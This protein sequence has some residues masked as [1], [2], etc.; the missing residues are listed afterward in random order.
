MTLAV[1]GTVEPKKQVPEFQQ[2]TQN[3]DV[4]MIS[5]AW[6]D[7]AESVNGTRTKGQQR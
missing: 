4:T 7:E 1:C 6:L 5:E 3:I 2:R